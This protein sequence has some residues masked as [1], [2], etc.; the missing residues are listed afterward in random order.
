MI[1]E[2][3]VITLFAA[4]SGADEKKCTIYIQFD[5]QNHFKIDTINSRQHFK[6]GGVHPN[7]FVLLD[8]EIGVEQ[9]SRTHDQ[10]FEGLKE[11][12]HPHGAAG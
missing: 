2:I 4:F 1:L 9:K 10:P 12:E 6:G 7:F 11:P 5:M 3:R 8:F